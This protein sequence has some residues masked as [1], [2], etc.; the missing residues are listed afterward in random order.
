MV[1]AIGGHGSCRMD[2]EVR[3]RCAERLR[4]AGSCWRGR[5]P[6]DRHGRLVCASGQ[7]RV[8]GLH[9]PPTPE[10]RRDAGRD[11]AGEMGD[12]VGA[13]VVVD[14]TERRG[15]RCAAGSL[16]R[17]RRR[18][19]AAMRRARRK[20]AERR[21][22]P[23]VGTGRRAEGA[24]GDGELAPTLPAQQVDGCQLTVDWQARMMSLTVWSSRSNQ[25][26]ARG[27]T[28]GMAL[29]PVPRPTRGAVLRGDATP[30]TGVVHRRASHDCAGRR[31]RCGWARDLPRCR[32]P[33]A[34]VGC[35]D[36]RAASHHGSMRRGPR[37]RC[38]RGM[39]SSLRR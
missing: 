25:E 30:D 26:Y 24:G 31:P 17:A 5:G 2:G 7:E 11:L 13:G 3:N 21:R 36:P 10:Q 6:S 18:A 1:G 20:S 27:T 39:P 22:R 33:R 34:A 9:A 37:L 15:C 19:D 23:R 32:L 8:I 38:G 12:L 16:R 29:V 28:E 4:S 14:R 35:L